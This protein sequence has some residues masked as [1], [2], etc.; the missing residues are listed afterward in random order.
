GSVKL[1][2]YEFYKVGIEEQNCSSKLVS[3]QE[4]SDIGPYYKKTWGDV[5][6]NNYMID[7]I[8]KGNSE[9]NAGIIFRATNV[10]EGGEGKDPYLGRHF[11]QGYYVGIVSDGVML[12]KQNYSEKLLIKAEGEYQPGQDYHLRVIIK[13]NQF[14]IY[15]EDMVQP[16]ISYIDLK[17]I[18]HGRIGV[19]ANGAITTFTNFEHKLI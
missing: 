2:Y 10:S 7:V 3:E 14:T 16:K 18:S 15:L 17:P 4:M 6:W 12:V 5:G 9:M 11:Y 13:D 19:R 8:V 1:H